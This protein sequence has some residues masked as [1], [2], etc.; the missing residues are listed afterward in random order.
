MPEG[1]VQKS[2]KKSLKIFAKFTGKH[3]RWSLFFNKVADLRPETL[4]RRLPKE[5]FLA[6]FVKLYR[7]PLV[8]ACEHLFFRTD[9][10]GGCFSKNIRVL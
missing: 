7:A 8:V 3:L 6:N 9:F 5:A 2:L 1:G 10:F 4:F